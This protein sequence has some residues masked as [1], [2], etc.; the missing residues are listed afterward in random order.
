MF[1]GGMNMNQMMKQAQKLQKQMGEKQN[2]LEEKDF[3]GKS[4]NDYVV[5]TVSGARVV[6]NLEIKE[7]VVDPDDVD[8]LSDMVMMAVND[9]LSQIAKEQ[10]QVLG[11]LGK[12]LPF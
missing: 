2:A 12:G 11:G 3:V 9:A 4:T 6:K 7:D 5:A 1:G 10:E 8:L